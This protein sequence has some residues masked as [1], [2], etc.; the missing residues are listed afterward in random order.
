VKPVESDFVCALDG[1]L[2]EV[3]D[4]T[5]PT[6]P[7]DCCH[8]GYPMSRS[9]CIDNGLFDHCNIDRRAIFFV[10][11]AEAVAIKLGAKPC[12]MTSTETPSPP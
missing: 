9:S 8:F 12:P 3:P 2:Y 11:A 7:C 5:A 1:P 6:H 4:K 10:N